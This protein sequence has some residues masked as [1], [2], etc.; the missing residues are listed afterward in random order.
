MANNSIKISNLPIET[1][2]AAN[3]R[4]VVLSANSSG[5]TLKTVQSNTVFTYS[6]LPSSPY[7]SQRAYITDATVNTFGANVTVGGGSYAFWLTYNG[8]QW[9]IG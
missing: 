6:T 9:V 3:D 1:T 4:I 2:L 5:P 7:Q 8:T